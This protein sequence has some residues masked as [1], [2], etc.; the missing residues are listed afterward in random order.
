MNAE[1]TLREAGYSEQQI[2]DGLKYAD[3]KPWRREEERGQLALARI[4][5]SDEQLAD[6]ALPAWEQ[7]V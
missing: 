5:F 1:E 4:L 6:G 7:R 3:Q 2:A